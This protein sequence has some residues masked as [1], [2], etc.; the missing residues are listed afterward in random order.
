MVVEWRF[1]AVAAGTRLTQRIV[2]KGEKAA[3]Y[4]QPV[5]DAFAPNLAAGMS[6]IAAAIEQAEA[7]G[8]L[9]A[10]TSASDGES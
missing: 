10:P 1:D 4:V 9:G 6:R 5:A 7:R 2:L 3:E 8:G